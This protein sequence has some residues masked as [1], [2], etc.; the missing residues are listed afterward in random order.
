MMGRTRNR[1]VMIQGIADG[2]A[3]QWDID[4]DDELE[5]YL[6]HVGNGKKTFV[7]DVSEGG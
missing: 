3:S 7:V 2:G 4:E 6:E 1:N 5:A